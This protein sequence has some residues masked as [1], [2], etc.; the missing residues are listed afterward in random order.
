MQ[1]VEKEED[2]KIPKYKGLLVLEQSEEDHI[3]GGTSPIPLV[4][5]RPDGQHDDFL[6]EVEIQRVGNQGANTD[7]FGCVTF[8]NNNCKE[9]T[10]KEK[11]GYE[12]NMDDQFLMVGSGTVPYQGNGVAKVAE[13]GRKNGFI[14]EKG[15]ILKAKTIEEAFTPIT[16]EEI[17]EGEESLKVYISKYAWLPRHLNSQACTPEVLMEYL[18]CFPIQASVDGSAYSFNQSGYIGEFRQ[19]THEI[20][21]FGYE[22]GKYWKIFDSETQQA[23]KFAWDYPLGY[24]MIHDLIKL[25]MKILKKKGQPAIGFLNSEDGGIYLWSDGVIA[26]GSLFKTLGF[27]YSLAEEVDEWP[28]PIKGHITTVGLQSN[29]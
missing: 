27:T 3:L 23:L 26:G 12:I 22:K 16:A 5:I 9:T 13:W 11:Y 24:P 15:R 2:L 6:P 21:V 28:A 17:K 19:Y 20:M 1:F 25:N 10:H 7:T 8:S 29:F 14:K 18:K 4:V